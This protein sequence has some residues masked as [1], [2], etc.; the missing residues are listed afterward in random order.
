[1][2]QCKK[3]YEDAPDELIEAIILHLRSRFAAIREEVARSVFVG[4]NTETKAKTNT[5]MDELN[6]LYYNIQLFQKGIEHV[7]NNGGTN[8]HQFF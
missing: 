4:G 5:I 1:M 6:T 2:E 3:W 7:A 8:F